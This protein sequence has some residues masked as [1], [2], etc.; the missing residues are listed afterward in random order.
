MIPIQFSGLI[1]MDSLQKLKVSVSPLQ[2]LLLNKSKREK[3]KNGKKIQ[4]VSSFRG[5]NGGI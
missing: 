2:Y 5:R 1:I 3:E 4:M